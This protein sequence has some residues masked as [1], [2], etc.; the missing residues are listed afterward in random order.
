VRV[1]QFHH[2]GIIPFIEEGVRVV[3][4]T[5]LEPAY[6]AA[7]AP[8]T[9]VSTNFTT[10]AGLV[11]RGGKGKNLLIT[12]QPCFTDIEDEFRVLSAA[13]PLTKESS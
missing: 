2:F 4:G 8:Q 12:C 3:P 5:G 6:L 13:S 9:Y 10:R 1:Y 11:S 7:Y